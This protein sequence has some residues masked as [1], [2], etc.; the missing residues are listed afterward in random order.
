M[1]MAMEGRTRK[2]NRRDWPAFLNRIVPQGVWQSFSNK[3]RT[4]ED[5]RVR[6]SRKF[7]VL[8]YIAMG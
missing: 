7:I 5:P 1:I 3:Q 8:A 2:L 6:W 4:S